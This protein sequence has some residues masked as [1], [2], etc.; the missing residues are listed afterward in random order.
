M[1]T[2]KRSREEI[3]REEQKKFYDDI[4]W[5]ERNSLGF[6]VFIIV[7]C[8]LLAIINTIVVLLR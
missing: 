6:G 1:S 5:Q 4:A 2:E 3:F 8:L 7:G